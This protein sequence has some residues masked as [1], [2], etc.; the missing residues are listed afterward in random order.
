MSA[1]TPIPSPAYA[2]PTHNRHAL[3]GRSVAIDR[4]IQA[5]RADLTDIRL[6]DRIF[7]PHY[8][9]PVA[10]TAI[11]ITPVLEAP[12]PTAAPLSQLLPGDTFEVLELTDTLAWGLSCTDGVVGYVDAASLGELTPATHRVVKH[13]AA[14]REA[15]DRNASILATLPLGARVA[16][17]AEREPFLLTDHGYVAAADV[18]PLDRIDAASIAVRARSLT[19]IAAIVGGRSLTGVDSA[20]L[21]FLTLDL[22]GVTAPRFLDLQQSSIGRE[23]PEDA[24]MTAGDILFFEDRAAIAVDADHALHVGETIT[25]IEPLAA[26]IASYG[27]IVAIRRVA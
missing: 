21:V 13:S 4:R 20:G 7:A 15:P 2:A 26:L 23:I 5:A 25:A 1:A 27:P 12:E 10:R 6:C 24:S 14:L 11:V 19:G 17:L 22:C 9:S 8:A 16:A 18:D 3:T